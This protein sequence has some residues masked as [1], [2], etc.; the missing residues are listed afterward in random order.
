MSRGGAL[1]RLAAHEGRWLVSLVW[2]VAR[3]RIGV[4]SGERALGYAAAQ[5]AFVYGLA[6]VCVVETVGMSVLFAGEPVV[7]GV[8]LVLDVYTVLMVL[9]L[10]AAAVTRPH[11]LGAGVLWLRDGARRE[12]R[13]P[14][15][16]IASVRYDLRFSR[17]EARAGDGTA[18]GVAEFA[19]GGQTSVTVELAEPVM[20]VGLLGRRATVGTVRFHADDP[21]A[22]VRTVREAVRE[23][24]AGADD[25]PVA[26][27]AGGTRP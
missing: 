11:V 27:G 25:G 4:A 1:R 13:I 23:D 8:L 14:V 3:R 17:Q 10:Q 16:R 5:A 24:M 6:F 7:H 26:G 20:V 21:R 2:W 15:G 9:G 19:V 22:A 12:L 18:A